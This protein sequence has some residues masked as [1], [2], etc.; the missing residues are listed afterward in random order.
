MA[1]G[2]ALAASLSTVEAGEIQE[3]P[4]PESCTPEQTESVR[5]VSE[6]YVPEII[7]WMDNTKTK[8]LMT[9]TLPNDLGAVSVDENGD[10]QHCRV[11]PPATVGC[12][13]VKHP[14][15]EYVDEVEGAQERQNQGKDVEV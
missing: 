13:G 14:I 2:I 15:E 5:R 11:F 12:R 3:N 10:V 8:V 4:C 1:V 9:T 6:L 7:A